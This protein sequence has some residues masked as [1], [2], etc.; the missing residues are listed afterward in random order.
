MSTVII[1]S[2]LPRPCS[3]GSSTSSPLVGGTQ[4][5]DDT[6]VSDDDYQKE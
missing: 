5:T 2:L 1:T 3:E 4:H 6:F